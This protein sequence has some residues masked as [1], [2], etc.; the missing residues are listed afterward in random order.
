MKSTAK[1]QFISFLLLISLLATPFLSTISP[2]N[3][4]TYYWHKIAPSTCAVNLNGADLDQSDVTG[5]GQFYILSTMT[6]YTTV[7]AY[8]PLNLEH[9]DSVDRLKIRTF[10]EGGMPYNT[11]AYAYLKRISTGGSSS[12]LA[13]AHMD[14]YDT[15]DEASFSASTIDNST[16]QY[17]V[18]IN[19]YKNNS[20]GSSPYISMIEVRYAR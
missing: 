11:D 20:A 7:E 16:Y 10:T 19:L 17:V 15:Y 14:N 9:G 12:T 18:Q 8:C 3:A 6:S 4:T 1:Y 5:L 2:A 13:T